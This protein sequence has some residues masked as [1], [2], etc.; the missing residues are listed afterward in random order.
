MGLELEKGQE[1]FF[2]IFEANYNSSFSSVFG[3]AALFIAF[4]AHL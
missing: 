3:I 1:L 2:Q 4:K